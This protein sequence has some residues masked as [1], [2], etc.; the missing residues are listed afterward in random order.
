MLSFSRN[1]SCIASRIGKIEHNEFF[2]SGWI[3]NAFLMST[4]LL[5]VKF[6]PANWH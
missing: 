2:V 6:E 3:M 4:G 5:Q 1:C